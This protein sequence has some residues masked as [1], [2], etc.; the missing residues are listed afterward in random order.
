MV[1][2]A[3]EAN[4]VSEV[5]DYLNSEGG[6]WPTFDSSWDENDFDLELSLAA[7]QRHDTPLLA[8]DSGP[9]IR[10]WVAENVDGPGYLIYVSHG[11]R[12]NFSVSIII[13]IPYRSS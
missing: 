7:A 2:D 9:M 4:A 12:D 1:A 10:T 8:A 13:S 5:L 11:H 6:A 3:V